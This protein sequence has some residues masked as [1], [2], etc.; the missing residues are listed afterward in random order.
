MLP[1]LAHSLDSSWY[2]KS[3]FSTCFAAQI[4]DQFSKHEFLCHR[5]FSK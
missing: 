2:S 5:R 4:S 1:V 3:I